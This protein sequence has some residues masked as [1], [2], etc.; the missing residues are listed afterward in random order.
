VTKKQKRHE[1]TAVA[2]NA[3]RG[4]LRA[5]VKQLL[6]APWFVPALVFASFFILNL[7]ISGPAVLSDEIGYLSK[8]ATIAGYPV[9]FASSWFGG[10]ALLISPAFLI[11]RDPYGVWIGVLCINAL[12]W[13][14]SAVLLRYVLRRLYPDTTPLRLQ[15]VTLGALA[16]PG[17]IALSGYAMVTSGFVFILLAT[18]AALLRSGYRRID[19]LVGAGLLAGYL[20]WIHPMG[21]MF[22][23]ALAALLVAR[24]WALRS[25]KSLVSLA[26]AVGMVALYHVGAMPYFAHVMGKSVASTNP[27]YGGQVATLIHSSLHLHFW[28]HSL[29]AFVGLLCFVVVATFGIAVYGTVPLLNR[30]RRGNWR[31]LVTDSSTSVI[32][33]SVL[34]LLACVAATALS[35][36][37]GTNLRPD[38]W[39]YGR[40][41]DMF[42]LPVIGVG[43]MQAWRMKWAVWLA[44]AVAASGFMLAWF[45]AR[46]GHA[47]TYINKLDIA[48]FWPMWLTSI[49]HRNYFWLWGLL[50][51]V[52]VLAVGLA[53]MPRRRWLLAATLPLVA[54][55]FM[56]NNLFHHSLV[57]DYGQPS[58]QIYA[59]VSA[60]PAGSCV[61]FTSSGTDTNERYALYTFYLHAYN[62][63]RMSLGGWQ[64]QC[65]GRGVYLTYAAGNVG[66]HAAADDPRYGLLAI[67]R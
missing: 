36:A 28:V 10:Y 27:G 58:Q 8:A 42:L 5:Q 46:G 54:A 48:A 22:V 18:L 24:A 53:G 56:A 11:T 39:I 30:L 19:W 65:K 38:Q 59:L 37:K 45:V 15:L 41:S 2:Q 32:A 9:Q 52:G 17:W 63:Q 1:G 3:K 14:G 40:Y 55:V 66:L 49:V 25:W 47:Y 6:L 26:P 12:M 16:Y 51:A 44:V 20:C 62:L 64:Q 13:A 61:G 23:L 29:A 67:T 60:Q 43:L 4:K 31:E 33:L 57:Q 7:D 35:N 34:A 21:Y 50:G